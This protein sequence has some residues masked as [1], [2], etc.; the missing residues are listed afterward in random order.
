M[1]TTYLSLSLSLCLCDSHESP[2]T[3]EFIFVQAG[4]EKK[5]M[6]D[7]ERAGQT[8]FA[9]TNCQP[10]ENGQTLRPNISLNYTNESF[11]ELNPC[12]LRYL[13]LASLSSKRKWIIFDL[14]TIDCKICVL[15][16]MTLGWNRPS[17][18]GVGPTVGSWQAASR[19]TS[20]SPTQQK[21]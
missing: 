4:W 13:S 11:F 21:K 5:W 6:K 7:N 3:W 1:S 20:A 19:P 18:L 14:S 12:T 17:G 8:E 15:Y 16:S 9:K 2:G 10:K